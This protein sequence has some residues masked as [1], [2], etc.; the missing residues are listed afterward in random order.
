MTRPGSGEK[1][2]R[3]NA[4]LLLVVF[5][6]GMTSLGIELTASRFI[7]NYFG[8]AL[9]V[10]AAIIGMVLTYLTIG[11]LLG[12]RLADR[13]PSEGYL[14]RIT[15]W[16][17]FA[18]GLV[19]FL[20][21]PI[22]QFATI[23]IRDVLANVF[24]GSLIGV[25]ILLSVPMIL[26]G[27]VSP[28]AIRLQ[29]RSVES[30]GNT[31]GAIYALSTMGS[32]LGTYLP[33]LLLIPTIGTRNTSLLFAF[34]LMIPSL[35][36]LIVRKEHRAPLYV[37]LPLFIL[38]LAI[39]VPKSAVRSAQG[40]D[41]LYETESAYNY[42]QVVQAGDARYLMLNEG[43]AVHSIYNPNQVLTQGEWDYFAVA[44]YFN[45]SYDPSELKNVA[46][47][48][49]AAGTVPRQLTTIYGPIAI[50]GVE[51]DPTIAQTGRDYFDMNLPN[52]NVIIQDGRYFTRSTDK[53][54]DLIGIDAYHQPYIPAQLTTAEFFQ[55]VH[56]HL[57]DRGV[58][59]LN[60]GRTQD[61]YRL[62][63]A[64]AA[65]MKQVFPHV[66][67]I[68][69]PYQEGWSV[70]N[71]LVV[72]TKDPLTNIDNFVKNTDKMTNP[73]LREVA[74]SAVAGGISEFTGTGM[75]FTD[76][77]APVEFVTD[78]MIYG[79]ALSKP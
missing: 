30:S 27:C 25:I 78:Q 12:G 41:L 31:A 71:T 49:L 60:A 57:S 50:D 53:T 64:L 35:V 9:P 15:M 73:L 46:V 7:G 58:V 19:P 5:I 54:Y 24:V 21:N 65:T 13:H 62:L 45:E 38:A 66:Y 76:D 59:L 51:I 37:V 77:R 4:L 39:I 29:T 23:G 70:V 2:N 44:P 52:L 48:G 63:N 10:W 72:G 18:S 40:G 43:N 26:L 14:Y 55:E 22:L 61:D 67:T 20:A 8:T 17:G 74:Q 36:G 33:V 1:M 47:I 68:D 28:F 6:C 11:Y 34:S 79:Y 75:I 32:I 16:A 42:I 69:I 56:D 3:K